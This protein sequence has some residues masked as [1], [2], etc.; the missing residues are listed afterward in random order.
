MNETE[1]NTL[2]NPTLTAK[3]KLAICK[4]CE[5]FNNTVKVCN[6]CH[7]FMPVKTR[8]PGLHCPI[9]KW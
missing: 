9:N 6:V 8:I 1:N 3:E 2:P 5:N 7:C 4:T